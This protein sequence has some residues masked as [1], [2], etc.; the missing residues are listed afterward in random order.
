M[1]NQHFCDIFPYVTGSGRA[2]I[3]VGGQIQAVVTAV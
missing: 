1:P 3:R 2:D